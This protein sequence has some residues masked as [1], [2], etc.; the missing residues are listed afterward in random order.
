[1]KTIFIMLPL[2]PLKQ[3][4]A[5]DFR[6]AQSLLRNELECSDVRE[7]ATKKIWIINGITFLFF[8]FS[9]KK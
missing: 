7:E 2:I 8:Y 1:M 6:A 9:E 5:S 4:A 3:V